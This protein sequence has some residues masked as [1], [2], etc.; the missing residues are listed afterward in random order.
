MIEPIKRF[1]TRTSGTQC[2]DE[3]VARQTILCVYFYR[4][5]DYK[6]NV[7]DAEHI[8]NHIEYNVTFRPGR[9]MFMEDQNHKADTKDDVAIVCCNDGMLKPGYLEPYYDKAK[10]LMVTLKK[11]VN[12]SK[13]TI[14]YC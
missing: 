4:N 9:I 5:G 2:V 13:P 8:C 11:T 14:P 6:Y 1:D 3:Y 10:E 7:V 12:M